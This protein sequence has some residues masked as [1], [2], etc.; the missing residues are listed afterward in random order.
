MNKV[1]TIITQLISDLETKINS[2]NGYNT[3]PVIKHGIFTHDQIE[4]ELPVLCVVENIIGPHEMLGD[5]GYGWVNIFMYGYARHDGYNCNEAITSLA[6]DALKFIMVDFTY[7]N[8]TEFMSDI[9]LNPGGVNLPL[10]LLTME[11][12][13]KFDW[14]NSDI[15][16]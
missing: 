11:I 1:N 6:L 7:T 13:V 15:N 16:T 8:D 4:N 9:Q 3:D 2:S 14:T 5:H 12:R 10:S